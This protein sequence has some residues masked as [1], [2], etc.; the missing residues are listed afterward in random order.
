MRKD[1]CPACGNLKDKRANTCR[2]CKPPKKSTWRVHSSG[3]VRKSVN[4]QYVYQHR[5]VMEEYLGRSL[6]T[7]EH[8]HHINHNKSDNRIENLEIIDSVLHGQKHLTPER[9]KEMSI[10]GHKARWNNKEV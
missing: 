9:A 7:H 5:I 2:P 3:Y 10:K 8:V 6:E 4:G 1:D